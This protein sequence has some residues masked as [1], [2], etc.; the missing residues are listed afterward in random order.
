ME[1]FKEGD[2]EDHSVE[3]SWFEHANRIL[4]ERLK[5]GYVNDKGTKYS[6]FSAISEN[7]NEYGS[8][9]DTHRIHYFT[10]P[11]E[12]KVEECD[13]ILLR[14]FKLRFSDYKKGDVGFTHHSMD[15][16]SCNFCPKCGKDINDAN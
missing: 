7:R 4:E 5:V 11:L 3:G 6:V 12:A 1:L 10:E 9:N 14:E 2:F 13:H 8:Q 15:L 16:G